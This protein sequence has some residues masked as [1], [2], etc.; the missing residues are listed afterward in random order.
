MERSKKTKTTQV[1][2]LKDSVNNWQEV[3]YKYEK[4]RR[5]IDYKFWEQSWNED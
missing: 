2:S 1:A 5:D 3:V 4:L